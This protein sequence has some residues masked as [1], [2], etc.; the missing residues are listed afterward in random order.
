MNS[1]YTAPEK[2]SALLGILLFCF[3]LGGAYLLP[4]GA[5]SSSCLHTR[6]WLSSSAGAAVNGAAADSDSVSTTPAP[7]D[8]DGG[9]SI[10]QCPGTANGIALTPPQPYRLAASSSEWSPE[11]VWVN[12]SDQPVFL[13]QGYSPGHFQPPKS[14]SPTH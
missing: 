1:T 12:S 5:V 6:I 11:T 3:Q 14:V 8:N 7:A 2:A 10:W 9:D 4:S 13:P